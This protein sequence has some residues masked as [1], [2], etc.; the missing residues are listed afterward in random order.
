MTTYYAH[1]KNKIAKRQHLLK[2]HLSSVG[3]LVHEFLPN[4]ALVDEATLAGLLHDAGK[5][6]DL[7]QARLKGEE[8][9]IDHWSL[10]AWL[11]LGHRAIAATLA[12]QGH[13]IGLQHLNRN[14]LRALNPTQLETNHPLQLRLSEAN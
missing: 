7:F 10:G 3:K 8:H 5:Y 6:G 13:H 11:A 4:S 9:G 14:H 12:I 2:D 1:S